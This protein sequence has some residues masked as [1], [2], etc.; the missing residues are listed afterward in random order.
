MSFI[1]KKKIVILIYLFRKQK[2]L[3]LTGRLVST[4]VEAEEWLASYMEIRYGWGSIFKC[5]A[6]KGHG[7][8]RP[9][10]SHYCSL[11]NPS[12]TSSNVCFAYV[13]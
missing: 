7:A 1:V 2:M 4:C 5:T 13:F 8:M 12:F 3:L 11:A 10:L 6:A 9:D